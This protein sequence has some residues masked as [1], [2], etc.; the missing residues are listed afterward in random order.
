MD[1]VEIC[2]VCEP[3]SQLQEMLGLLD[4]DGGRRSGPTP[5]KELSKAVR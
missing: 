4:E 1:S 2:A 5:P 3:E